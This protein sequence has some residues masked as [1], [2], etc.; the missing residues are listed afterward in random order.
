VLALVGQS[1]WLAVAVAVTGILHM[2]VVKK[3]WLAA[4][5][6]PIDGGRT[7]GGLPIFGDNKT[8]RG[9]FVMI[10]GSAA[11]GAFQ[12]LLGGAWAERSGAAC[13][14]FGA[15]G[16][17]A[18]LPRGPL[19]FAF[20]YALVNA[21]NGLGYALGELP[22]SFAKR[23]LQI[24]PGKMGA[25]LLGGCFFLLDQAD[26]VLA[27]LGLGA[28]VFGYGWKIFLVGSVCLTLLH[29]AINASL[30][31]GKVRKNL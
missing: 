30:Y 24:T 25:G 31:A 6:T 23:R 10:V 16:A 22:N 13:M 18:G 29:L 2:V 1:F 14:D 3:R 11:L 19:A 7:L 26:S 9:V 20:G 4:L 27:A 5:A 21:V 12:G 28:L 15:L 8:W 17:H